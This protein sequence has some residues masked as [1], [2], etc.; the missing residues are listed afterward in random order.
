MKSIFFTCGLTFFFHYCAFGQYG[1]SKIY[2]FGRP[3]AAYTGL[4]LANDTLNVYGVVYHDSIPNKQG[5]LFARA[6]T[7][8]NILS[9]NSYF[10]SLGDDYVTRLGSSI[11]RLSNGKGFAMIGVSLHRANGFIIFVDNNGLLLNYY[12]YPDTNSIADFYEKLIE[13]D[14]GFI[15]CGS[16]VYHNNTVRAFM[17]KIDSMGNKV[18][19]RTYGESLRDLYINSI[20]LMNTDT[21]VLGISSITPYDTPISNFNSKTLLLATNKNGQEKWRWNSPVSLEEGGALALQKTFDNNWI[22]ISGSVDINDDEWTRQPKI[23]VRDT[24]FNLLWERKFG[25]SN[26]NR[27]QFSDLNYLPENNWVATGFM[28]NPNTPNTLSGVNFKFSN[29]G[30]SIWSRADTEI[31]YSDAAT[32]HYISQSVTLPSGSVI[33]CG[34]I[35]DFSSPSKSWAWLLKVDNNGCV[36]PLDCKPLSSSMFTENQNSIMCYPNPATNVINIKYNFNILQPLE[37]TIHDAYFK[38]KYKEK[39]ELGNKNNHTVNVD[40]WPEGIYIVQVKDLNNPLKSKVLKI[41]IIR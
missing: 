32:Y 33:S 2:D 16:K 8:G 11:I 38:L 28:K 5:L 36:N 31:Y 35:D 20:F 24:N 22:Y 19:E 39:Q 40:D 26:S 12:E 15:V 41:L 3:S 1:F 17:V 27:N 14:N 4:V 25:L 6:D 34:S 37:I 30:D 18:W 7:N 21:Y 29:D 9:Y 23:I 13:V 10:D